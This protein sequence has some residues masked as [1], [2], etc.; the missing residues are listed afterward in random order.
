MRRISTLLSVILLSALVLMACAPKAEPSAPPAPATQPPAAEP[1]AAEPAAT[2][3]PTAEAAAPEANPPEA[4]ASIQHTMI[5][6]E[7]PEYTG[8]HMGDH[9]T[10]TGN[11]KRMSVIGDQFSKGKFER[12]YNTQD[13]YFPFL[14]I[15]EVT[16]YDSDPTWLYAVIGVVG[17]D[18][19][20]A[21]PGKYALEVDVDL[22]GKGTWLILVDSPSSSEWTTEQVQVW[23]DGNGDVGGVGEMVS[24]DGAK[25]GDGYETLVFDSGQGDDPDVAWVRLSPDDPNSFE[26]A[27]KTSLFGDDTKYLISAW[28]GTDDLDPALFDLNDHFTHEQA[29]AMNPEYTEFYPIKGLSELDNTCR[30]AIGFEATGKEKG[31]CPVQ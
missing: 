4:T 10:I 3:P 31:S 26:I 1:P 2:E 8:L 30:L 20:D 19:N 17:R 27:V 29:G 25:D 14:D 11:G 28:A 13:V 5:P 9:N 22:T 7:L 24:E 16:F 23:K 15:T 6:G 18:A 12:P 21:F